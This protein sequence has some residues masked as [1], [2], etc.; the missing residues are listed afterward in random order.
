[1]EVE[2]NQR[3][4]PSPSK[5]GGMILYFLRVQNH[6][7]IGIRDSFER[8][9]DAIRRGNSHEPVEMVATFSGDREAISQLKRD[10]HSE[11]ESSRIHH[12]WFEWTPDAE[13]VIARLDSQFNPEEF[14]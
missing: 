14:Q 2:L 7:K 4:P 11:L 5:A 12:E 1:M 9:L 8:R 13:A 10:I 3:A 6:L